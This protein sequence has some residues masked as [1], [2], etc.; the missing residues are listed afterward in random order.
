[1]YCEM[2]MQHV[3]YVLYRAL[4]TPVVQKFTSTYQSNSL[5]RCSVVAI[6]TFTV[7]S[8]VFVTIAVLWTGDTG[9]VL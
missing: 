5:I 2:L 7:V 6:N 1:M 8:T 3:G 9:G 4:V